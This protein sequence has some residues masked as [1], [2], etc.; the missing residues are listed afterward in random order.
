[1][2][3]Y[4]PLNQIDDNPYQSR[5]EYTEI[6]SL[7]AD[8]AARRVTYPDTLG[9]MQLPRGRLIYASGDLVSGEYYQF[10]APTIG[11]DPELRIQLAFGHRRKRAFDHLATTGAPGYEAAVMPLFLEALSDAE[12]LDAVWSENQQR[13][14][15][16]AVEQAEL[17]K[18]KLQQV[19]A[20]GGSQKTV[21][22][23][24]QLDRSTVANKLRLLEL[25]EAAQQANREGKLSERQCLALLPVA[26]LGELVASGAADDDNHAG[27]GRLNDTWGPP[28]SP[29]D[30]IRHLIAHSEQITSDQIREYQ[31][32]VM[33]KTGAPLPDLVAKTEV[34][35][36]GVVQPLCKGCPSRLNQHCLN[37]D[38]LR[39]KEAAVG[40]GIARQ[41]AEEVGLEYSDDRAHFVPFSDWRTAKELK[42]LYSAGITGNL[43]VG[44][45]PE[46]YAVRPFHDHDYISGGNPY[47]NRMGVALG[48]KLRAITAEEYKQLRAHAVATD[49]E[50]AAAIGPDR[51]TLEAWGKRAKR[52]TSGRVKRT[53]EAV[54]AAF[55]ERLTDPEL[56][57]P[58]LALA[59]PEWLRNG[60]EPGNYA[61]KLAEWV[62]SKQYNLGESRERLRQLLEDAGLSPELVDPPDRHLRLQELAVE[63]LSDWYESRN[64]TYH[65]KDAIGKINAAR[66]AFGQAS[67]ALYNDSQEL[68][69]LAAALDEAAAD[70]E[71]VTAE[72][73]EA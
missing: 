59:A 21:A 24:W 53:K 40:E 58:L 47:G 68:C 8:I 43:V 34:T 27:W 11:T 44:W 62:W 54:R 70:V 4:V 9:L 46:G 38:C 57:R 66:A 19:Q 36:E 42:E 26:R 10:A 16:S 49:P 51:A 20:D 61:R 18:E 60:A 56:L 55:E 13:R 32:R 6:E 25:P 33:N 69:E 23:S 5:K 2:L 71:R 35:A 64:W 29:A 67:P 28:P 7:A 39:I 30:F 14:D 65:R 52:I 63:A 37:R 48:H 50:S 22:E 72:K 17:L 31:K 73:Q 41:A 3:V 15:I 1:M 45:R 12:M